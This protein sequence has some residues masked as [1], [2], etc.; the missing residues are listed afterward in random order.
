MRP[1]AKRKT[2]SP[3]EYSA[4]LTEVMLLGVVALRAPARRLIMTA[5]TCASPTFPD[6][7]QYFTRQYSNR[8]AYNVHKR[9]AN[10]PFFRCEDGLFI[11]LS[12]GVM[13]YGLVWCCFRNY[14]WRRRG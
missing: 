5:R 1:K 7:N 11:L 10:G 9:L 12:A 13:V 14:F 8:G 2:D 4:K 6:A 3:F